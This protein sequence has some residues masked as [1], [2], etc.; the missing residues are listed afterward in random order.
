MRLSV[1]AGARSRTLVMDWQFDLPG[2]DG[3]ELRPEHRVVLLDDVKMVR[4]SYFDSA[5]GAGAS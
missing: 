4:F 2:S 1:I 3:G 5:D